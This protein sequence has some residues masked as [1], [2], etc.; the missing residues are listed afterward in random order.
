MYKETEDEI[1]YMLA[2]IVII[3][4]MWKVV[5]IVVW[6]VSHISINIK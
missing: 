2:I 3:L 1:M 5:D 4:A 6:C